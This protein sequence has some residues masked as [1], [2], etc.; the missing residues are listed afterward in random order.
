MSVARG[1][2]TLLDRDCDRIGT[3]KPLEHPRVQSTARRELFCG[4]L[5]G[6]IHVVG[7]LKAGKAEARIVGRNL[8]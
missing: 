5:P 8:G 4:F 6:N 7:L 2:V 1:S 3:L